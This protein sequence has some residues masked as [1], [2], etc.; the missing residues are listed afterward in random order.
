M[1]R[2]A[3]VLA[4]GA[5]LAA[6]GAAQADARLY[7]HAWYLEHVARRPEEA[8]QKYR[9][10]CA[11]H[12]DSPLR[13]HALAR[14]ADLLRRLRRPREAAAI[15]ETLAREAPDPVLLRDQEALEANAEKI[16]E[17]D[18]LLQELLRLRLE[19]ALVA[20]ELAQDQSPEAKARLEGEAGRLRSAI[21]ELRPRLLAGIDPAVLEVKR[22]AQI[23]GL[24]SDEARQIGAEM[25]RLRDLARALEDAGKL[26]EARQAL[27]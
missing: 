24:Q 11:D 25:V 21:E 7:H 20:K 19:L 10:L 2:A 23:Q 14:Q 1:E 26:R 17:R 6:P 13:F 16:R 18:A 15:L 27:Q 9:R 4:F 22:E 8:L 12:P 5:L 3:L